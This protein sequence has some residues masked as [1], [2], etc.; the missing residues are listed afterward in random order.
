MDPLRVAIGISSSEQ[1]RFGMFFDSLMHV[2]GVTHENVI[3]F[4]GA[5][6][7]ENRNGIAVKAMEFGFHAVWYV[8]DDQVFAPNTLER[9]ISHD[10]DIVSGLYVARQIP[11]VPHV[12]HQ[13]ED[14]HI[15]PRLLQNGDRSMIS[16]MVTGAGCLL[17]KCNVFKKMEKP[18]WRL[19]EADQVNWHDDAGFCKRARDVGFEVW[20]DQGCPVGHMLTGVV[21]PFYKEEDGEWSTIFIQ[22]NQ[23]IASWPAASEKP[24]GK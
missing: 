15:T 24:Q 23:L 17:V 5:N 20:C 19:G 8:D 1:P 4:R 3:Y 22:S 7:A 21:W 6:I 12:Y 10:K 11:F 18:W 2:R 13:R 9:L 14:G 16:A